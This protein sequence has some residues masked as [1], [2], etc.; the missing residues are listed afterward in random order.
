M[1]YKVFSISVPNGEAAEEALNE[2]L[3]THRVLSVRTH[4][5]T[6]GDTPWQIFTV[7][8]RHERALGAG[9]GAPLSSEATSRVDYQ[10]ILTPEQFARFSALRDERRKIS[11][12]EKVK[13]Y[14]V[15]TNA[16]LAALARLERPTLADLRKIEGVGDMRTDT[17]GRRMLE[18]L[19]A[20]EKTQ[21]PLPPA[22][23]EKTEAA[24]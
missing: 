3:L 17:Y 22:E 23:P 14:I 21:P 15:F 2:F 18:A 19:E 5:V 16:Q 4:W 24:A 20:H 12:A 7:E 10:K 13:A 11:D 8:Y 9:G 1:P 6:A